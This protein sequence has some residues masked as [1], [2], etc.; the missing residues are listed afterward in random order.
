[1]EGS[2]NTKP[3]KTVQ[4]TCACGATFTREVKRGRPQVWC[5]AC[6]A[7]PFYERTAAPVAPVA[8]VADVPAEAATERIVNENDPLDA[9]RVEVEAGMALINLDHKA[10]Y[11]AFLAAGG[12]P[13]TPEADRISA[14][15]F[16]QTTAL[17]GQFRRTKV[18]LP[19][20]DEAA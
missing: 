3:V 5:P 12:T 17:Y 13:L 18:M 1:M 4:A 7:I 2:M 14:E 20:E 11:A 10:R 9:V 16:A 6:V 8:P 15:T 19:R